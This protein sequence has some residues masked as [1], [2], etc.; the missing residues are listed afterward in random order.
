MLINENQRDWVTFLPVLLFAYRTTV[1]SST[2]FSPF[3][4][5]YGREARQ[6]SEQWIEDFKTTS[7]D[8]ID[9]YVEKLSKALLFTWQEAGTR[10]VRNQERVDDISVGKR[11]RIFQPYKVGDY[12]F[13]KTIAKRWLTE[14][15]K[16]T[17]KLTRKLQM[18]YTGPHLVIEVKNP[19]IYKVLVN[20]KERMVH[21]SKMKRD[22]AANRILEVYE[23]DILDIED[24]NVEHEDM[25]DIELEGFE[26]NEDGDYI[27]E[28]DYEYEYDYE[29]E[30]D[31]YDYVNDDYR[32]LYEDENDGNDR[33][34]E[35][36]NIVNQDVDMYNEDGNDSFHHDNT[37]EED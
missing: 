7:Q 27:N 33:F 30:H 18:R 37:I 3:R 11:L 8:T 20:G 12:F 1:N 29:Y 22:P 31:T 5:L 36:G 28:D 15:G 21:A 2:G 24:V 9:T 10:I 14:E 13:L 19:V 17:Y 35:N 4:C 25:N 26:I 32:D 23:D 6:P 34:D 16:K